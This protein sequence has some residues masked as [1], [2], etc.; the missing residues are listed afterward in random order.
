MKY[1]ALTKHAEKWSWL[2]ISILADAVNMRPSESLSSLRQ[3][4]GAYTRIIHK[5]PQ[6][7]APYC[8]LVCQDHPEMLILAIPHHVESLDISLSILTHEW[9]QICVLLLV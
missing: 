3:Q 7:V 2:R 5:P 6:L 4:R 8:L 9:N 1:C